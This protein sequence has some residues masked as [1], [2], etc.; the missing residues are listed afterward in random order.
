MYVLAGGDG[1]GGGALVAHVPLRLELVA[2]GFLG[3]DGITR[4]TAYATSTT[5]NRAE[6]SLRHAAAV[7]ADGA[8]VA[9]GVIIHELARGSEVEGS[10]CARFP[11]QVTTC[12]S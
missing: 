9:A 7:A 11:K 2:H 8:G 6:L 4:E 10:E 3:E 5:A 12:A 1:S